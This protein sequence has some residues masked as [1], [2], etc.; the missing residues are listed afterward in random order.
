MLQEGYMLHLGFLGTQTKIKEKIQQMAG[1]VQAEKFYRNWRHYF[2]QKADIDSIAAWGFNA[3]RLPLHYNLFTLPIQKEPQKGENTWLPEG[4]KMVDSLLAWCS[5]AHIYLILDLHAAPGGQGNDLPIS[6]RDP[7]LPSLWQSKENQDKTVALW[8]QLAKRYKD[9]PYIGG[10]DLLNETNWGF[11]DSSD[12]RG[13]KDTA[14]TPL[15]HFLSRLTKAVRKFDSRHLIILEGNGFANNYHGLQKITDTNTLLSFHKYGNFNDQKAIAYFLALRQKLQVPILMGEGGENS[16]N[17]YTHCAR[18][19]EQHQIGWSWWPLKKMGINNPLEIKVPKNYQQ[20][21]DFA[22]GK[23]KKPD[24]IT[25]QRLLDDLI[26]NIQIQHNIIH[27]DV[28]HSLF[29]EVRQQVSK[30]FVSYTLGATSCYMLAADY[31][32][33]GNGYG[34]LDKDTASYQYTPGVH[35]TGNKG[36]YY[37]NDGVDIKRD[38][39]T[40]QPIIFSIEAGEW[41]AYSPVL[42]SQGTYQLQLDYAW[43]HSAEIG[44]KAPIDIW[45]GENIIGQIDLGA[46]SNNPAERTQKFRLSTP[47]HILLKPVSTAGPIY[48]KFNNDGFLLRGLRFS[49]EIHD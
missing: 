10:Y 9:A 19:L 45:Q 46:V 3:I 20:F 26:Q 34:Y 40:G 38:S 35:T 14:N 47:I 41:L 27:R 43:E 5:Q 17:W 24:S 1:P 4:F 16:N 39:T 48:L 36:H 25:G 23:A 13:T 28:I 22:A 21:I 6:D 30:P 2:I 8:E 7:E 15:W 32:L 37:R 31:N 12:I 29:G 11:T 42:P 49:A 18:L 33:G 44:A